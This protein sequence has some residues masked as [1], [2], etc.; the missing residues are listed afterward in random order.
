MRFVVIIPARYASTRLPGKPLATAGGKPLVQWVYEA[1]RRSRAERV[2]VATE[3]ERILGVVRDFGG[4]ALMTAASHESGTDRIAEAARL[5]ELPAERIVLNVQGDEP[6]MTA[7]LVNEVAELLDRRPDADMATAACR[8]DS[9]EEFGDPNVVKVVV[10]GTGDALYFSRAGIPFARDGG[11]LP[12]LA[13]RHFGIYAYRARFL[14]SWTGWAPCALELTER[15]EQLRALYH[16]ARIA[17]A[18]TSAR[19]GIAIDTPDD[20]ARW[21]K[22]LGE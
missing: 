6:Q 16:G 10:N 1:A 4:E 13:L 9:G 20:L 14:E 17:V 8:L 15:L 12:A 5:L 2:V 3:D 11:A 22:S 19:P 7:E 21:R 18:V